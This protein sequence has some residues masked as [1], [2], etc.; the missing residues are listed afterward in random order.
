[1]HGIVFGI[2]TACL[3]IKNI[4]GGKMYKKRVGLTAGQRQI[5]DAERIRQKRRVR[6]PFRDIDLSYKL[7][8]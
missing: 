8:R 5:A 1:M 7:P 4:V 6:L 3:A 2:G